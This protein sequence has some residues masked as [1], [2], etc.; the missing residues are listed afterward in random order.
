M[1]GRYS[2]LEVFA[3]FCLAIF[4]VSCTIAFYTHA[5]DCADTFF[6]IGFDSRKELQDYF[7][8]ATITIILLLFCFCGVC[9][10]LNTFNTY[11]LKGVYMGGGV[12]T[13]F[14]IFF[15]HPS[16]VTVIACLILVVLL[17]V[18]FLTLLFKIIPLHTLSSIRCSEQFNH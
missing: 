18:L 15:L 14:K 4:I 8:T 7:A 13:L 1:F 2:M 17:I 12:H 16:D 9:S 6:S 11:Y 10:F 5:S 3:Y